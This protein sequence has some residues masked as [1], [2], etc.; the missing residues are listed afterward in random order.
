MGQCMVWNERKRNRNKS[1]KV[2]L[3]GKI[4]RRKTPYL[5]LVHS[6]GMDGSVDHVVCVAID[7]IFYARLTHAMK[8]HEESFD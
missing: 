7:V 2:M 1:R 3:V 5:T 6:E 8:S 4:V